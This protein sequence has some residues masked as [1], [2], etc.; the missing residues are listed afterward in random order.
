[1]PLA[2]AVKLKVRVQAPRLVFRLRAIQGALLLL[3]LSAVALTLPVTRLSAWPLLRWDYSYHY[4]QVAEIGQIL[5]E[6]GSSWGYSDRFFAG[7]PVGI[8]SNLSSKGWAWFVYLLSRL[9]VPTVMAF[10][11]YVALWLVATPSLIYWACR[12]FGLTSQEATVATVVAMGYWCASPLYWFFRSGLVSF[13]A[14]APLAMFGIAALHIYLQYGRWR[15][16]ATFGL[17]TALCGWV[18]ALSVIFVVI[19]SAVV[20]LAH[21]RRLSLAKHGMLLVLAGLVVMAQWPWLGPVLSLRKWFVGNGNHLLYMQAGGLDALR[22]STGAQWLNMAMPLVASAGVAVVGICSLRRDRRTA[23]LFLAAS[24]SWL[25]ATVLIETPLHRLL[26]VG[27]VVGLYVWW[28]QRRKALTLLFAVLPAALLLLGYKS[29]VLAELQPARNVPVAYLWL[30]IP[31]AVGGRRVYSLL[32]ASSVHRLTVWAGVALFAIGLWPGIPVGLVDRYK[33][34]PIV[35]IQP[36]GQE[37]ETL[38]NWLQANTTDQG[39]ILFEDSQFWPAEPDLTVGYLAHRTGRAFIGGPFPWGGAADFVDAQAFGRPI[40]EMTATEMGRYL[41]L[42]NIHWVMVYSD[43]SKVFFD[44]RPELVEPIGDVSVMRAFRVRHPSGYFMVGTGQVSVRRHQ[45]ELRDLQGPEV[46]VKYH[47]IPG[48]KSAPEATIQRAMVADDP[49]G[50]IKIVN[51]PEQLV[52][53]A[54]P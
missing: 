15:H 19:G 17:T 45:I 29:M 39:R 42:Y 44:S 25:C 9:S 20:Y 12:W 6:Q 23:W 4:S 46:V 37:V 5:S 3:Y 10:N 40:E 34:Q 2:D 51:P 48:L 14:S 52:L 47:W 1:M 38:V 8:M 22:L 53:W 28:T 54:G 18:H 35:S 32:R 26:L 30:S 49:Y 36:P 13:L 21:V 16:W 31:A 41:D 24:A 50:F 33:R 43:K 7:Y 11:L 27:G